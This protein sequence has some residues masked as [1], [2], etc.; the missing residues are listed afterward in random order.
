MDKV[1]TY[2]KA[3]CKHIQFA[4]QSL[5]TA[6]VMIV[7]KKIIIIKRFKYWKYIYYQVVE[8]SNLQFRISTALLISIYTY[9]Q[10]S[11]NK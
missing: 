9:R 3:K 1:I 5:F 7:V 6:V 4:H 8:L 2:P 11:R 10:T